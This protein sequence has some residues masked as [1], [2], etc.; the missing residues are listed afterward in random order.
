MGIRPEAFEDGNY[1][2]TSEYSESI[3]VSVSL[4]EQLGS[5]S[6]NHLY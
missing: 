5:D 1:A 3:K 2:N 6:Y 4:L